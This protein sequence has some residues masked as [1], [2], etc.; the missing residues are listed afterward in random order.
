MHGYGYEDVDYAREQGWKGICAG[1][2]GYPIWGRFLP[3]TWKASSPAIRTGT[4]FACRCPS[5]GVQLLAWEFTNCASM[6]GSELFWNMHTVRTRD[7]EL[8]TDQQ[9]TL[10]SH[11]VDPE[12]NQKTM[13]QITEW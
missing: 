5:C 2:G 8:I 9:V 1:C 12:P 11:N 7:G 3:A 6:D 13:E 4:L 10:W